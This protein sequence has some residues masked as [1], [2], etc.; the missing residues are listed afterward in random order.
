MSQLA[1]FYLYKGENI[2][3]DITHRGEPHVGMTFV[4]KG[5]NLAVTSMQHSIMD[6]KMNVILD[7]V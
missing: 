3:P 6:N 1:Y 2:S 4:Y 5:M 7:K